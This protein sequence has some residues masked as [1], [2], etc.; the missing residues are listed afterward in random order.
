MLNFRVLC[1]WDSE[2]EIATCWYE[3]SI[4]PI[5]P[6]VGCYKLGVHAFLHPGLTSVRKILSTGPRMG[7]KL[8]PSL[9]TNERRALRESNDS[10]SD[11]VHH[12]LS[13]PPIGALLANSRGSRRRAT[14]RNS[15]TS[16]AVDESWSAVYLGVYPR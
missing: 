3:S 5:K 6:W 13:P 12:R 2:K 1:R 15:S 4:N 8:V 14:W 9:D 11:S 16:W 10:T 7:K